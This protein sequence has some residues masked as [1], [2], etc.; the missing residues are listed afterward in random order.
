LSVKQNRKKRQAESEFLRAKN[1]FL[2]FFGLIQQ[3][4]ITKSGQKNRKIIPD[5]PLF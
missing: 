3:T 2:N 5:C 1:I 4:N